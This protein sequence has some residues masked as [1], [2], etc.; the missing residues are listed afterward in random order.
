VQ[1]VVSELLTATGANTHLSAIGAA[2][3]NEYASGG[4]DLLCERMVDKP[5]KLETFLRS[6]AK[7][8]VELEAER[9]KEEA[10]F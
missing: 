7:V 10:Q 1:K 4:F 8:I 5:R 9:S 6:Y 2:R 3:M